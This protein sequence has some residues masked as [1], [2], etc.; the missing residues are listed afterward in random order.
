MQ[1]RTKKV[2]WNFVP[3]QIPGVRLCDYEKEFAFQIYCVTWLRQQFVLSGSQGFFGWHHSANERLGGRAGFL[4]KLMGQSKGFPD[5]VNFALQ[6]AIELKVPGGKL[7]PEQKGWLNHLSSCGWTVA[8]VYTFDEFK[9][10]I[11]KA[12]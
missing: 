11:D 4:A 2:K 10:L 8:V 5:L 12:T 3:T 9:A 7:S 1:K 6:I